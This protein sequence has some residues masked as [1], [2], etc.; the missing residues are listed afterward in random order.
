MVVTAEFGDLGPAA[1]VFPEGQG[2]RVECLGSGGRPHEPARFAR[3]FVVADSPR[4]PGKR[5]RSGVSPMS[6]LFSREERQIV[7]NRSV[8]D[9]ALREVKI[10]KEMEQLLFKAGAGDQMAK[11]PTLF[12]LWHQVLSDILA[13]EQKEANHHLSTYE[14][15]FAPP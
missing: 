1:A 6:L 13:L 14:T 9:L 2:G 11:L 7:C 5:T 15:T 3:R 12:G 4:T 10:L 8:A